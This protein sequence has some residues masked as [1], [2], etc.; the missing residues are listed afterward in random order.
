MQVRPVAEIYLHPQFIHTVSLHLSLNITAYFQNCFYFHPRRRQSAG[1]PKRTERH[2]ILR[3]GKSEAEVTNNNRWHWRY[4]T[5]EANYRHK[6]SHGLYV[7]AELLGHV[8]DVCT[9]SWC[10]VMLK[11]LFCR[12]AGTD[13]FN[14]VRRSCVTI[15]HIRR[16]KQT[17]SVVITVF[18]QLAWH[19]SVLI[20]TLVSS[21]VDGSVPYRPQPHRPQENCTDI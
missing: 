13:S 19:P 9:C 6:V 15:R 17:A 3:I 16:D 14:V 8:L 21:L 1:R 11:Q 12:V 18:H 5:V 7:T 2:L 4:C 20:V 10:V